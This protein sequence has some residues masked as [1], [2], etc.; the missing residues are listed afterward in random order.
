M[1]K[2]NIY[3]ELIPPSKC[4]LH[5]MRR[6]RELKIFEPFFS[7][8]FLLHEISTSTISFTTTTIFKKIKRER[9]GERDHV[10][11]LAARKLA[12]NNNEVRVFQCIHT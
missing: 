6:P 4:W 12:D 9:G 11:K 2:L 1:S 5:F 7:F 8:S 3:L 10:R